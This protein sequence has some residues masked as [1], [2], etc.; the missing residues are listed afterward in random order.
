MKKIYSIIFGLILCFSLPTAVLAIET[1]TTQMDYINLFTL[2]D[3]FIS[4]QESPLTSEELE[5]N[6]L[7]VNSKLRAIDTP[8]IKIT[9]F[10]HSNGNYSSGVDTSG[11]S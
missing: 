6:N 7:Q 4:V 1:I 8:E 9:I 10:S 5:Y 3:D 2:P 11:H